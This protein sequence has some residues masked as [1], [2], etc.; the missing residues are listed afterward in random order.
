MLNFIESS[1]GRIASLVQSVGANFDPEVLSLPGGS[2]IA[3]ALWAYGTARLSIARAAFRRTAPQDRATAVDTPVPA[4]MQKSP[5]GCVAC[6]GA[7]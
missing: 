3:V 4:P 2:L 7:P 5:L 6:C 1:S